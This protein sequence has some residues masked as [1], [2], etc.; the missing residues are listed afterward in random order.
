M[1]L[2]VSGCGDDFFDERV[3]FMNTKSLV[4]LP[5]SRV[6]LKSQDYIPRVLPP[7]FTSV[8]L[9]SLLLLN[10]FWVTNITPL[11]TGGTA[12]FTYWIIGGLFFFIPCSIVLAQLQALLPY[13]GG[14]YSWTYYAL[15]A[16][17]S[18]FV[19][20]CAWLP[21]ILSMITAAVAVV[22]GLQALN[23]NWLVPTWQ[24]GLAICAILFLSGWI[25]CQRTRTVQN[26]LNVAAALM[27]AAT[28]LILIAAVV[29]VQSG[30]PSATNFN[31][32]ASY[33]IIT[34]GPQS[35]LA[36]LGSVILALFGSDMPLTMAGEIRSPKAGTR[37][38][39]WGT[40]LALGGYLI[41]TGALL[42]IQGVKG[43]S[44]TINPLQLLITTMD[45]VFH[46]K[47]PGAIMA[48][49]LLLYFALIPVA[50]N[51]C[52][53]R[54]LVTASADYRISTRFAQL[55]QH[56]VPVKALVAQIGL[57]I[58]FTILIFFIVP[59]F[60][61]AVNLNS[62]AY[63]V[64]G[65]SLLLVWAVSFFFP[66]LDVAILYIRDQKAFRSRLIV[67]VPV[68]FLC[69]FT[70]IVLCAVT[71]ITTLLNS[72]IPSLI[73]NNTWTLVIGTVAVVCLIICATAAM[74]TSSEAGFEAI[75]Q[76]TS[77][78]TKEER[79]ESLL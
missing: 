4:A 69:I 72:F 78:E 3:C 21:G 12:S 31:D 16:A 64:I 79:E 25:S 27:L 22:S 47:I 33:R 43:A 8:D 39:T 29:W 41:W 63:N 49:I 57:A 24:Q 77:L 74:V 50:L 23:A 53:A 65:A 32:M 66:F 10:V 35:N 11:V 60:G 61:N 18:Y 59:L 45:L 42:L 9:T 28:V 2:H 58:F 56:R 73:P 6:P 19:S 7:L 46:N 14:I 67:P 76:E 20:I 62:E 1:V 52:F 44:T 48:S 34:S 30:H 38:L 51:I 71:I 13:E 17:W 15:G 5:F 55:N 36:L 68:L 70:G 75:D 54:L 37:H 40:I 26:I